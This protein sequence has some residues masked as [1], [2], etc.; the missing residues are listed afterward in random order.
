MDAC[1]EILTLA[2]RS[3]LQVLLKKPQCK[4]Q[5]TGTQDMSE[6][7][8]SVF[9]EH[10][11]YQEDILQST[12]STHYVFQAL[13]LAITIAFVAMHIAIW[14]DDESF[15]Q[16]TIWRTR[17]FYSIS[18]NIMSFFPIQMGIILMNDH[19]NRIYTR[20][21][22]IDTLQHLKKKNEDEQ[23]EKLLSLVF[24]KIPKQKAFTVIKATE[25]LISID[26]GRGMDK[27]RGFQYLTQKYHATNIEIW[28]YIL[29]YN[30]IN[31]TRYID[32]VENLDF[33][34][35]RKISDFRR[36]DK[37]VFIWLWLLLGFNQTIF[38][39]SILYRAS[40][41]ALN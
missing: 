35:R 29:F 40:L 12:R 3:R 26:M 9:F 33:N 2:C 21:I 32:K 37:R 41:S 16:F 38:I 36:G 20:G 34:K 11:K 25:R 19:S 1:C 17:E 13:F 4:S 6:Q 30:D 15:S 39:V 31:D 18:I 10:L 27:G 5:L 14:L 24:E 8:D 23:L 22:V 28:Q 7:I